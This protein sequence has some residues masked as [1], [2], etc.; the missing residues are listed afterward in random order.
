[1]GV[2]LLDDTPDEA[3]RTPRRPNFVGVWLRETCKINSIKLNLYIHTYF[4]IRLA[5]KNHGPT[6]FMGYTLREDTPDEAAWIHQQQSFVR[7][8]LQK[9]CKVDKVYETIN[10][11]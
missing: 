2:A 10:N 5:Q 9:T 8:W 3:A 4:C 11:P 1:M 7:V 6:T